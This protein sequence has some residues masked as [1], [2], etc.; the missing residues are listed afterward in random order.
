MAFPTKEYFEIL[1]RL[2]DAQALLPIDTPDVFVLR[3]LA[4]VMQVYIIEKYRR[5]VQDKA[6]PACGAA[7]QDPTISTTDPIAEP[8]ADETTDVVDDDVDDEPMFDPLTSLKAPP[9]EPADDIDII[10]A[11]RAIRVS[12]KTKESKPNG[13]GYDWKKKRKIG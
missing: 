2:T 13:G 9:I 12:K 4:E 1:G 3:R 10:K 7:W 6:Q 5:P 8:A 11:E